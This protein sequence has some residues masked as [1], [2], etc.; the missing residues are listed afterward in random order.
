MSPTLFKVYINDLQNVFNAKECDPVYAGNVSSGCL[1][2]ADDILILSQSAN[3]LQKSL[4]NL[5]KYCK[6]WRL[7]VNIQ[8]TK[9]MIFNCKQSSHTFTFGEQVL[10]ETNS[11]CYLGFMLTPSGK[12]RATQ[13]YLGGDH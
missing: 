2:Y 13:K 3:G 12:F 8:K 10:Q 1:M 9:T 4:D 5:N 7:N 6:K 11:V